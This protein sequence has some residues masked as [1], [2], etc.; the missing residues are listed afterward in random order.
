M[1]YFHT[2]KRTKKSPTAGVKPGPRPLGCS[3]RV[4][5]HDSIRGHY[6]KKYI[7]TT[8][9][10]GLMSVAIQVSTTHYTRTKSGREKQYSGRGALIV[11]TRDSEKNGGWYWGL[12]QEDSAMKSRLLLALWLEANTSRSSAKIL[13]RYA[14]IISWQ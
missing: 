13:D 10:Q 6:G 11:M 7:K 8:T 5:N 2:N 1:R 4:S 3:N 12:Y 9:K 14:V